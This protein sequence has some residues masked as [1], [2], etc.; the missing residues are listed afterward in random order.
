[1][2]H[3]KTREV[4][5]KQ[6]K[7]KITEEEKNSIQFP[8]HKIEKIEISIEFYVLFFAS[9]D[10][11]SLHL[12]FSPRHTTRNFISKI[13]KISNSANKIRKNKGEVFFVYEFEKK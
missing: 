7:Q 10:K 8:K 3:N 6:N 2:T 12:S 9:L 4:Q 13:Y 1:M 5:Y 11:I